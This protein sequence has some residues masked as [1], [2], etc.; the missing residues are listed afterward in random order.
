MLKP[1]APHNEDLI[2]ETR[3]VSTASCKLYHTTG[4]YDGRI[5]RIIPLIN[6]R[7]DTDH[8]EREREKGSPGFVHGK[9]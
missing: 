4:I 6:R 5:S 2:T 3:S 7:E 8:R 1:R 9:R